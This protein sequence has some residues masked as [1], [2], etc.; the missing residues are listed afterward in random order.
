MD[1]IYEDKDIIVLNKERGVPCQADKTGCPDLYSEVYSYLQGP[2]HLGLVHR[3][4]RPVGGVIVFAKN[5]SFTQIISGQV[6]NRSVI[7]KYTALVCGEAKIN[8]NL[9]CCLIKNQRLNIS[10]VVNKNEGGAKLARLNYKLLQ[11]KKN[12][13]FGY[14][15]IIEIELFT[16]RHH[17]IRAQLA[18]AGLPVYGDTK[19]NKYF[20]HNKGFV[21]MGLYST[22]FEFYNP[23]LKKNMAFRFS[24]DIQI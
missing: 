17:Q 8:E 19:Y 4:D 11:K 2:A 14:V 16:G 22:H 21:K 15:S 20:M 5:K 3:L 1:I 13:E 6:S 18:D 12:K 9:E 23:K 7:K 24:P 10:R